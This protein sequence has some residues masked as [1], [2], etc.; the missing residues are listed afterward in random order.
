MITKNDLLNAYE[1][2][3][4]KNDEL[5][6]LMDD[7]DVAYKF[8]KETINWEKIPREYSW[9]VWNEAISGEKADEIM[10][11]WIQEQMVHK[12]RLNTAIEFATKKAQRTI[13]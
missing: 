13:P 2:Y 12:H 6:V 9:K 1:I 4:S 8:S 7:S 5:F 11:E 10:F 3:L